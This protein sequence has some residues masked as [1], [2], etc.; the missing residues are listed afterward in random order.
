[1]MAIPLAFM[2]FTVEDAL[3]FFTALE[4]LS[5]LTAFNHSRAFSTLTCNQSSLMLTGFT[6]S[7][8]T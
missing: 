4:Y 8:M 6:F 5:F 7:F 2:F 3:T 1:M